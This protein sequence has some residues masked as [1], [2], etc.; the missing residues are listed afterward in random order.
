[1]GMTFEGH[2]PL[3]NYHWL[4]ECTSNMQIRYEQDLRIKQGSQ[5]NGRPDVSLDICAVSGVKVFD[6]FIFAR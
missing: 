6:R 2:E 1:M 3:L 5:G 4:A